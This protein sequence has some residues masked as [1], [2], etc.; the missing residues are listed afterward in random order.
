VGGFED[1]TIPTLAEFLDAC[2]DRIRLNVELKTFGDGPRL[3][4]AVRDVLRERGFLQRAVVSCFEM[5]PLR[6]L[7][8]AEPELPVGVILSAI[9]GDATRLPVDFL[10]VQQRL[11]RGELVRRA[12]RRGQQ[13]HAWGVADRETALRLLD[14]GCD[15]LITPDPVL[16]RQVVDEYAELG[17]LERMLLRLRQWLRE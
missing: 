3:A 13:V 11:A 10:S 15:N 5:P 17:D 8:S 16:V 1:E 4:L 6:A 9:Q 12:H 7:R 14:L 2:D